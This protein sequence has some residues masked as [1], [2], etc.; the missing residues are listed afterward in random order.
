MKA[1]YSEKVTIPAGIYW[2]GDPCYVITNSDEWTHVCHETF[3]DL[4]EPVTIKNGIAV[5]FGTSYGDGEYS[6]NLGRKILVDSGTI[7][8]VSFAHNP[9]GSKNSHLVELKEDAECFANNG[10][11]VFG[12][13][14]VDTECSEAFE[15]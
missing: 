12:D 6:D 10:V 4:E 9:K 5:L 13:I 7:G 3:K 14:T 8:L 15:L 2:L 11:L 1:H